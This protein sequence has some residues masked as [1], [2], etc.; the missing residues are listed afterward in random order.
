MEKCSAEKNLGG[1][2][3][4][5]SR[6]IPNK[7]YLI[8]VILA[9]VA[10]Y[11]PMTA[12]AQQCTTRNVVLIHTGADVSLNELYVYSDPLNKGPNR[13]GSVGLR[14]REAVNFEIRPGTI[15]D[16][17]LVW[18]DAKGVR[19]LLRSGLEFCRIN[20]IYFSGWYIDGADPADRNFVRD[21]I[22]SLSVSRRCAEPR[23][24][25]NV[26][27]L[28][29]HKIEEFYIYPS[30]SRPNADN[31]RNSISINADSGTR[32]MLPAAPYFDITI[33]FRIDNALHRFERRNVPI[34][35]VPSTVMFIGELPGERRP[36]QERFSIEFQSPQG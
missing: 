18:N 1:T 21:L 36:Q 8:V 28:T 15:Y 4:R 25:L 23:R 7:I 35:N 27:N 34:C 17:E 20:A 30:S 33:V 2:K 13:L 6:W 16:I 24:S 14:P 11:F 29:S 5:L 32:I 26:G 31:R 9:L 10:V 12:F 19:R 22:T 3:T